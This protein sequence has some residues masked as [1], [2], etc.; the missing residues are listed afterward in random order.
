MFNVIENVY[1]V[2]HSKLFLQGSIY[3]ISNILKAMLLFVEIML[4]ILDFQSP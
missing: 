2:Q 3:Y 4:S 1:L